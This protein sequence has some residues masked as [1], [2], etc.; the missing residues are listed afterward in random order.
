MPRFAPNSLP[1]SI[2]TAQRLTGL[3][4]FA[5]LVIVVAGC[6]PS[7]PSTTVKGKV[8]LKNEAVAGIVGFIKDGKEVPGPINP[9]GTY[10]VN[11][12]PIG[13]CK[14]I[15]KAIPG[16]AGAAPKGLEALPKDLA[17]KDKLMPAQAGAAGLTPP[18]RYAQPDNGLT[19]TVKSGANN[20]DIVLEP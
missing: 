16:A 17:P 6:S 3:A 1:T 10:F 9:D 11:D 13:T 20:H 18:P 8:T 15:V 5:G 7:G 14:I 2:W 4:L 12:P 19:F